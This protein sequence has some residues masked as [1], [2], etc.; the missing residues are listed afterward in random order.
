MPTSGLLHFDEA[1]NWVFMDADKI[2]EFLFTLK[3]LLFIVLNFNH[4]NWNVNISRNFEPLCTVNRT[5][6]ANSFCAPWSS[7]MI[8]FLFT[9]FSLIFCWFQT[10]MFF[11][12]LQVHRSLASSYS[13][14]WTCTWTW[15]HSHGRLNY[16]AVLSRV[17][18]LRQL[19]YRVIVKILTKS[20]L[21]LSI[22]TETTWCQNCTLLTF[23]TSR[24][25]TVTSWM[26][27][28][29]FCLI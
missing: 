20:N 6:F 24:I 16:G 14:K 7:K 25:F 11:S 21:E 5:D 29:C 13:W 4:K 27:I 9:Q 2:G 1:E 15:A 26:F 18:F 10:Q 17:S 19:I 3:F 12:F 28:L 23:A 22:L 8:D